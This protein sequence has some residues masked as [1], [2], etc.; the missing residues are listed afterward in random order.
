MSART[1]A[2]RD[3]TER[4]DELLDAA[5]RVATRHG[6][7]GLSPAGVAQESGR[8]KALVFHYFGSTDGLRRAVA[9]VA[10]DDLDAQVHAPEDVPAAQRPA[11]VARRF[12]DAVTGRAPVWRDVWRGT[13]AADA[14]TAAALEA[15]RRALVERMARAASDAGF[16][17]SPRAATLA[18]GWVALVETVTAQ[19]LDQDGPGPLGRADV[20]SLAVQSLAV[21]V[22]EV[23]A[24][25]GRRLTAVA[26]AAARPDA[27]R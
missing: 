27:S 24:D 8:S 21:L 2:R 19:W 17:P 4:R 11:L 12:L 18:R 10:I 7:V 20:E 22:P 15:V 14:E 9:R 25:L 16:D 23:P 26:R 13:L 1:A 6:L 3:P 5:L